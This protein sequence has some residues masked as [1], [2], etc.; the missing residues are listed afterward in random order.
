MDS[1]SRRRSTEIR[2][3]EA[4]LE[5]DGVVLGAELDVSGP[6]LLLAQSAGAKKGRHAKLSEALE[7]LAGGDGGADLARG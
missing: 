2:Q 4:G 3:N 7:R 5:A 1:Q 6:V